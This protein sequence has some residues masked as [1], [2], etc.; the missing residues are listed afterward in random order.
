[1]AT[2][3]AKQYVGVADGTKAP[4][5][6]ADGRQVNAKKSQIV[7]TKD[8]VNATAANDLIFIGR[9]RAG[10]MVTKIEAITDTTWGAV[11]ISI[12]TIASPTKYVN[13]ATLTAL[14]VPTALG[15][16]ASAVAAGPLTADED[17]YAKVSGVIAA[18]VVT[19]FI[20]HLSSVK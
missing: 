11:T 6:R 9:L 17:I 20:T 4:A 13:A 8:N 7:A 12:G 14:N 15:P 16:L 5:D 19:H 3:Y 10:E 1:M 18:A 2:Y